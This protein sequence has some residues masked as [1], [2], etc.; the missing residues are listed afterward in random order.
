[1][2]VNFL[3]KAIFFKEDEMILDKNVIAS[4][5]KTVIPKA[6]IFDDN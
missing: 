3:R 1:M 2:F 6:N 5:H 4:H